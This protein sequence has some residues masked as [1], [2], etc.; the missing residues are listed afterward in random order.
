MRSRPGRSR[1]CIR[2]TAADPAAHAELAVGVLEVLAHRRLG[3]AEVPRD[4]RVGRAGRHVAEHRPLL[5]R[6]VG[7]HAGRRPLADESHQQG[8]DH[9][10]EGHVVLRE[11]R[12]APAEDHPHEAV[13]AVGTVDGQR[14]GMPGAAVPSA[15]AGRSARELESRVLGGR[16]AQLDGRGRPAGGVM[17]DHH[18]AVTGDQ[19]RKPLEDVLGGERRP[20]ARGRS[21]QVAH[22]LLLRLVQH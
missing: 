3:D 2:A 8:R 14:P 9:A 15:D 4:L 19:C 20:R 10:R 13:R 16:A 11:R 18:D 12:Q 22:R 6:Q 21:Q 1:S 5:R 7:R 17:E